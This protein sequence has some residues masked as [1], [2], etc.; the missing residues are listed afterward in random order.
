MRESVLS[1]HTC[2]LIESSF[3]REEHVRDISLV[4]LNQLKDKFPQVVLHRFS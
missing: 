3:H 2:F 1:S 4:L